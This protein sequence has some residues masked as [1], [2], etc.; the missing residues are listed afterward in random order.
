M[1]P[2]NTDRFHL[3]KTQRTRF[4]K[5]EGTVTF[6]ETDLRNYVNMLFSSMT[7]MRGPGNTQ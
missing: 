6:G 5:N 2:R 4:A 3:P 1:F 7:R